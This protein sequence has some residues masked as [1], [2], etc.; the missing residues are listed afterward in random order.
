MNKWI[1]MHPRFATR[2]VER[3]ISDEEKTIAHQCYPQ[4][5]W[6]NLI[7]STLGETLSRCKAMGS[8]NEMLALQFVCIGNQ[9]ISSA[10]WNK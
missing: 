4:C 9:M 3:K 8:H 6:S 1:N 7:N 5:T 10:I 2:K